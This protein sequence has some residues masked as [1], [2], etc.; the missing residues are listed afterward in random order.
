MIIW[1]FVKQKRSKEKRREKKKTEH[2]IIFSISNFGVRKIF[3]SC[4]LM[5]NKQTN[6]SKQDKTVSLLKKGHDTVFV[7]KILDGYNRKE[8]KKRSTQSSLTPQ[9]TQS[10]KIFTS[11]CLMQK[12]TKDKKTKIKKN[13]D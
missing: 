5:Q 9:E 3:T 8:E 4:C 10:I 7:L 1:C 6:N 2:T 11:C 12:K 13:Y